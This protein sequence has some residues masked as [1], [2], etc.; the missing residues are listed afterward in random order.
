MSSDFTI[1]ELAIFGG[2]C[3]MYEI[4]LRTFRIESPKVKEEYNDRIEECMEA[5]GGLKIT[6]LP[7]TEEEDGVVAS[8]VHL[9]ENFKIYESIAYGDYE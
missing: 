7:P 6:G 9:Y 1:N 8:V 4:K 2:Y 3:M 5:L